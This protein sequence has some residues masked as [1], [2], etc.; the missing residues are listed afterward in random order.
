MVELDQDNHNRT[1]VELHKS[2]SL[3]IFLDVFTGE[4]G[5]LVPSRSRKNAVYHH[6]WH[7][8]RGCPKRPVV[9]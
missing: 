1:V 2:K 7:W 9:L 4:H 8:N 5:M 3:H 6:Q